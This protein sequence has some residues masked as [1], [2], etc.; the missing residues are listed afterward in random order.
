MLS[1]NDL[2]RCMAAVLVIGAATDS[3]CV[4]ESQ[5]TRDAELADDRQMAEQALSNWDA[6]GD[7]VLDVHEVLEVPG[8][9]QIVKLWFSHDVDQDGRLTVEE[10][11]R[12]WTEQRGVTPLDTEQPEAVDGFPRFWSEPRMTVYLDD[13]LR[14]AKFSPDGRHLAAAGE[15]AIHLLDADTGDVNHRISGHDARVISVAFS[16]DSQTLITA[17]LD[18]TA[19]FWNVAAGASR[20]ATLRHDRDLRWAQFTPDGTAVVTAPNANSETTVDVWA[21]PDGPRTMRLRGATGT[22]LRLAF[23]PNGEFLASAEWDGGGVH[24][25]DFHTGEL[26]WAQRH[27]SHAVCVEFSPD[28]QTLATGGWDNVVRLWSVDNGQ[29][30]RSIRPSSAPVETVLWWPSGRWLISGTRDGKI[31]VMN[32][33]SGDIEQRFNAHSEQVRGLALTIDANT[34]ASCSTDRTLK[35]WDVRLRP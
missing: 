11:T 21:V 18:R 22:I 29:Q 33:Q 14:L 7:N 35:L 4:A 3:A 28:G 8:P 9:S 12:V 2:G 1:L 5:V 15:E 19:K 27:S 26:L 25:W 31:A 6:N 34:V 17:S 30:I 20:G 32:V 16:P 23:S 10:L 24:V 13:E